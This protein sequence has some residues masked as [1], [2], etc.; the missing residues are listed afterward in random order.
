MKTQNTPITPQEVF[1]IM[2]ERKWEEAKLMGTKE[3]GKKKKKLNDS[4]TLVVDILQTHNPECAA[5]DLLIEK[6]HEGCTQD[7]LQ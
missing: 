6:K 2:L 1:N 7:C 4:A 5:G 3:N